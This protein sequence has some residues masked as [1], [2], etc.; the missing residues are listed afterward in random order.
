MSILAL[1]R[2]PKVRYVDSI[3][4]P[5]NFTCVG[6]SLS[7]P[8]AKYSFVKRRFQEV[9]YGKLICREVDR[10]KPD[11]VISSNMPLD[12]SENPSSQ[13]SGGRYKIYLLASG[14]L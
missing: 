6:L 14:Y 10:F 12:P 1:F 3:H 13:M 11:V 5:D 4:D 8:F 9:A 2:H 7:E